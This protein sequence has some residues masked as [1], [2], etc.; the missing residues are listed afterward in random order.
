MHAGRGARLVVLLAMAGR[1]VH[2]AGAGVGGDV[3]APHHHG[4]L[5]LQER[6]AVAAARQ[7]RARQ[8]A[9]HAQPRAQLGLQRLCQVLGYHQPPCRPAGSALA[10]HDLTAIRHAGR[11]AGHMQRAVCSVG[12]CS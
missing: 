11:P 9:Q 12:K 2:K 4:A 3:V 8:R 7:L 10:L 6:V 1:G 5:A